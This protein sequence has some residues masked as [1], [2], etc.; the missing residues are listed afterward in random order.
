MIPFDIHVSSSKVKDKGH[1]GLPHLVQRI[2][3]E[4]FI[5]EASLLVGRQFLMRRCTPLIFRSKVK[6]KGHVGPPT[7]CAMNDSRTLCPR[8]FKLGR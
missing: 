4:R 3:L 5:P 8:S 6:V 7:L 2:I 1:V